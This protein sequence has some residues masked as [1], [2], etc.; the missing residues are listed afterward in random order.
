MWRYIPGCISANTH[1]THICDFLSI[2]FLLRG[3]VTQIMMH[4]CVSHT[5]GSPWRESFAP[6]PH[7]GGQSDDSLSLLCTQLPLLVQEKLDGQNGLTFQGEAVGQQKMCPNKV[8][9][10]WLQEGTE[11]QVLPSQRKSIAINRGLLFFFS[12]QL[13]KTI[14]CHMVWSQLG[15]QYGKVRVPTCST[16]V[17]PTPGKKC[18]LFPLSSHCSSIQ[19]NVIF[20]IIR[21]SWRIYFVR[22]NGF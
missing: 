9:L 15:S 12:S 1:V 21:D 10:T 5:S 18:S 19:I 17:T 20:S 8:S 4:S 22:I 16:F 13:G 11:E 14:T 7:L 3:P 6:Y 2:T